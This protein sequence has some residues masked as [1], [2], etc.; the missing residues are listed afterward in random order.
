MMVSQLTAEVVSMVQR[1][2]LKLQTSG[3]EK[4]LT[5]L[6]KMKLFDKQ[7]YAEPTSPSVM[8]DLAKINIWGS[9]PP[10]LGCMKL[11]TT[12]KKKENNLNAKCLENFFF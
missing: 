3:S 12:N 8:Q 1:L 4:Y 9:L 11:F 5:D 7:S 10:P 2:T 6:V